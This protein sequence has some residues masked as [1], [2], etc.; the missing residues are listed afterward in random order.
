MFVNV[1]IIKEKETKLDI[2]E[3]SAASPKRPVVAEES[4]LIRNEDN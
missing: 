4:V 3:D 2:L 1:I